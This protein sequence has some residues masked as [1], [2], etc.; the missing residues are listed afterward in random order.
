V[1]KK[2]ASR[3]GQ[4]DRE[5]NRNTFLR[6]PLES[7]SKKADRLQWQEKHLNFKY[8]MYDCAEIR[9]Q[10]IFFRDQI[11]TALL[12]NGQGHLPLG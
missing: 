11:N 2:I 8:Q 6:I 10:S 12:L 5:G 9:G 7:I 1:A 3:P 4:Y